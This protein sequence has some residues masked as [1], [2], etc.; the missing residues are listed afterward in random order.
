[1]MKIK[2]FLFAIAIITVLLII[3]KFFTKNETETINTLSDTTKKEQNFI[4]ITHDLNTLRSSKI[5]EIDSI[6]GDFDGN[7]TLEYLYLFSHYPKDDAFDYLDNIFIF[8]DTNIKPLNNIN[9]EGYRHVI[10]ANV[11]DI[12]FNKTDE[13]MLDVGSKIAGIWSRIDIYTLTDTGWTNALEKGGF[14]MNFDVIEAMEYEGKNY[15]PYVKADKHKKGYVKISYCGF[16]DEEIEDEMFESYYFELKHKW[17]PL[18]KIE[19]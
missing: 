4:E 10:L 3:H 9:K 18:T 13:I 1:M 8:S 15:Y 12:N 16:Y 19:K 5:Y 6:K 7:G 14:A 17:V 11:G 2:Y